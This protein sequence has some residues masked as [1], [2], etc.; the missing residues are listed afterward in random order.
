MKRVKI[1]VGGRV[2][3]VGFRWWVSRHAEH[4]ALA[5]YVE[6]LPDGRVEAVAQG[7]ADD[8]DRFVTLLTEPDSATGRPGY[9]RSHHVLH[10]TPVAMPRRFGVR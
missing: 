4:L 7:P 2:Q 1:T 8:V 5:G 3:G 9:I 6:N 10:E